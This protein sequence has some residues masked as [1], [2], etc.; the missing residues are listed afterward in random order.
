MKTTENGGTA[1]LDASRRRT[2]IGRDRGVDHGGR[3]EVR[4]S[5]NSVSSMK[6][7]MKG[8]AEQVGAKSHLNLQHG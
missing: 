5:T 8:F 2:S 4:V 6:A 3:L 7:V 1:Q